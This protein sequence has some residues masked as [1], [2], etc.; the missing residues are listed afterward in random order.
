MKS[1]DSA[2][3]ASS[4]SASTRP[5]ALA[6][7]FFVMG[8]AL[9]GVW[10]HWRKPHAVPE[11]NVLSVQT[12]NFLGHLEAPVVIRFYS[13]LP[14]GSAGEE[15]QS[16]SGRMDHLLAAVQD[17]GHGRI[18]VTR[19]DAPV[20]SDASAADADGIQPFNLNKGEACYLGLTVSSGGRKESMA[21]LDPEWEPA[22]QYDL[23]RVIL[24]VTTAPAPAPLAP[25]I[26]K[27]SPEI[28]Q[29]INRLIPDI[30]AVSVEQAD[31]IF[32]VEFLKEYRE[33]DAEME[34]QAGGAEQQ[35]VQAQKSG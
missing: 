2:S 19:F 24:R 20:E 30:S 17:A 31:H 1:A 11:N 7:I 14:A 13:L 26:A 6:A 35:V 4:Q 25:E 10:F 8:A 18:Q 29:S 15:L 28:V 27:P 3:C 33:A 32:H 21:R 5:L 9:A 12:R 22:V 34:E 23:V 16:F